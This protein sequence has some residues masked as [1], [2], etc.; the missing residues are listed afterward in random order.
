MARLSLGFGIASYLLLLGPLTGIPAIL[1][2]HLAL[3]RSRRSPELHGGSGKAIA[4]LVLGYV[5]LLVGLPLIAV[6]L[7]LA[8]PPYLAARD[9]EQADQCQARMSL[10][11]AALR[12]H[13]QNHPGEAFPHLNSLPGVGTDPD[14]LFC[15]KDSSLKN[16]NKSGQPGSTPG[17]YDR[18]G[19]PN[20]PAQ[21]TDQAILR[22]P[23]HGTT[24]SMDGTTRP[25][26]TGR[27]RSKSNP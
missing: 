15:P 26:K 10:L 13:V 16:R 19:L 3:R 17:S 6:A 21:P 9:R 27:L 22:C 14:L 18:L 20:L 4:G 24:V 8:V 5:S 11:A 12:T 7:S 1:T 2:G 25:G 23:Y